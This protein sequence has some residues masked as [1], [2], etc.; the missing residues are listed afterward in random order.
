MISH[1]INRWVKR[2][3]YTN[4]EKEGTLYQNGSIYKFNYNKNQEEKTISQS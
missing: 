1:I 2:A 3:K 4:A